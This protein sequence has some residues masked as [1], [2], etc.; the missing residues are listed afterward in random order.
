[1]LVY[2]WLWSSILAVLLLSLR[3]S[4][5][6]QTHRYVAFFFDSWKQ[7]LGCLLLHAPFI[8][9]RTYYLYISY[10]YSDSL[11]IIR[12]TQAFEVSRIYLQALGFE[13]PR[14]MSGLEPGSVRSCF[15]AHM[16]QPQYFSVDV[17]LLAED[18]ADSYGSLNPSI[19]VRNLVLP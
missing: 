3:W 15:L 16:L 1:M 10:I 18:L 19:D 7:F 4:A 8:V 17:G 6:T 2:L 11:R 13:R 5:P 14:E 12:E 9:S